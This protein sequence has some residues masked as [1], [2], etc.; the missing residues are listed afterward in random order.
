MSEQLPL[1]SSHSE[2]GGRCGGGGVSELL[3]LRGR[4]GGA[5]GLQEVSLGLLKSLDQELS[6]LLER[7]LSLRQAGDLLLSAGGVS[8]GDNVSSDN[9]D[10]GAGWE[11][12]KDGH[13]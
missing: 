6:S 11:V 10:L 4:E 2:P 8:R 13:H 3:Q 5:G 12:Q 7:G 9:N 1:E